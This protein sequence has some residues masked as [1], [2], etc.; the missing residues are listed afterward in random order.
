MKEDRR[1]NFAQSGTR[2]RNMLEWIG[3]AYTITT[4][5]LWEHHGGETLWEGRAR[6]GAITMEHCWPWSPEIQESQELSVCNIQ[7]LLHWAAKFGPTKPHLQTLALS[8]ALAGHGSPNSSIC[9]TRL[10]PA[11]GR[12][13]T[14]LLSVRL[15]T[16]GATGQQL[17]V[18][19][20]IC[21]GSLLSAAV[22]KSCL[23]SC[24][25]AALPPWPSPAHPTHEWQQ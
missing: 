12:A 7:C 6:H 24:I 20:S 9:G 25:A 5:A 1:N 19:F 2:F 21:T 11:A 14:L 18:M 8:T 16:R 23:S 13:S 22:T 10:C 3:A 4:S 17:K 15:L